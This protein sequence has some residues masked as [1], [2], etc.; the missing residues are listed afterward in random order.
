[1]WDSQVGGLRMRTREYISQAQKKGGRDNG[2]TLALQYDLEAMKKEEEKMR[3]MHTT[4]F[5][6]HQKKKKLRNPHD[7][8]IIGD[9]STERRRGRKKE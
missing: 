7:I 3:Q 8:N 1:M 6:G 2:R 5:V 9:E 4:F